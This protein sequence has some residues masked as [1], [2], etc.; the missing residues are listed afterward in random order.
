MATNTE[1]LKKARSKRRLTEVAPSLRIGDVSPKSHHVLVVGKCP[2]RH[3]ASVRDSP[4]SE[5]TEFP[6][7]QIRFLPSQRTN[8]RRCAVSHAASL[9]H[10]QRQV[11]AKC[12]HWWKEF[13]Y[14]VPVIGWWLHKDMSGGGVMNVA[15]VVASNILC[16][17]GCLNKSLEKAPVGLPHRPNTGY[18]K[19][20]TR[21]LYLLLQVQ[22]RFH[23]VYS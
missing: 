6:V 5:H 14:A 8:P 11:P 1:K 16:C 4:L 15:V 23:S 9:K 21:V 10:F 7:R 12:W 20:F 22:N 19:H 2:N 13:F 18:N 3:P 17:V